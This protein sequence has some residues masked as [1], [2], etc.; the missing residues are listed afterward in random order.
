MG[1]APRIEDGL[2]DMVNVTIIPYGN[3][4]KKKVKKGSDREWYD[5][6]HKTYYS[7]QHG[8][9]E[10]QGNIVENCFIHIL[11][12]DKV[13]QLKALACLEEEAFKE[14]KQKKPVKSVRK[15]T[16]KFN[17]KRRILKDVK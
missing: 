12:H 9:Y 15:L 1:I 10:C 13:Q 4:E 17:S 11:R 7:C 2:L 3:A 6:N 5:K 16:K 14:T 8:Y